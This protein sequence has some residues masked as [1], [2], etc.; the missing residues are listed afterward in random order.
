MTTATYTIDPSSVG[1]TIGSPDGGAIVWL[2]M[3]TPPIYETPCWDAS[4]QQ[5]A[6]GVFTLRGTG[7]CRDAVCIS[8]QTNGGAFGSG[9]MLVNG[10]VGYSGQLQVV[11]VPTGS[12]W[13][14]TLAD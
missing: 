13:S 7:D 14:L 10:S 3:G 9:I 6:S 5:W 11:A 12:V 1:T 8:P 4:A 2:S